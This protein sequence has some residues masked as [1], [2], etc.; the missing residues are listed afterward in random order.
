MMHLINNPIIRYICILILTVF[1]LI[2]NPTSASQTNWYATVSPGLAD[3]FQ[4]GAIGAAPGSQDGWDG[5]VPY[6][7]TGKVGMTALHYRVHGDSWGGETGFYYKD[8]ESPIPAG[9]SKTWWNIYVWAQ[10]FTPPG[11]R[12]FMLIGSPVYIPPNGYMSHIVLDYIPEYLNW[13]GPTEF[14]VD[15][16]NG[17]YFDIPIPTVTNP[18]DGMRMHI[19][20]TAPIPEPSS[21]AALGLGLVPVI[22]RLRNKR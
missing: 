20:V 6:N 15:L 9:G 13:T 4:M 7:Y 19:T 5:Q 2:S 22:W 16:H 3:C 21:L 14:D 1:C 11:N 8:Y 18:L 17:G 10:N 12:F